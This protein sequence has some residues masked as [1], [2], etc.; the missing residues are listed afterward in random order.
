MP[1]AQILQCNAQANACEPWSIVITRCVASLLLRGAQIIARAG[2]RSVMAIKVLCKVHLAHQAPNSAS[3]RHCIQCCLRNPPELA[4]VTM[5]A[6]APAMLFDTVQSQRVFVNS[7]VTA[8]LPLRGSLTSSVLR[9]Y[10]I[11]SFRAG[12][13]GLF[14][15]LPPDWITVI[16][17]R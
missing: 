14:E 8:A 4:P 5:T 1:L 15:A 6:L 2:A 13:I 11:G 16:D 7:I 3:P 17:G 10:V 12:G 9:V